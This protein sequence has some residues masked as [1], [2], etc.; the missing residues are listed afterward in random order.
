MTLLELLV[1]IGVD[2]KASPEIARLSGKISGT[3]KAVST[4]IKAGGAAVAAFAASSVNVGMQFDSAMSQVAATMGTTT[5]QISEL[6]DFAQEMGRT[7]A[8]SAT[9]AAEALNYMAL[10]GYDAQT[11]MNMLPTVL[12]LAAAGGVELAEASDMVTDVQSALGLTIE[13]TTAMVDQMAAASSRTN[14]SVAQLG[15]ALLTVGGTARNLSGGTIEAATALGLLADN[16]IKGAEGGT[17]LRNILLTLSSDKFS[18]T[19]GEMGVAV[20][21]ADGNMR[22][23]RDIIVDMNAAMEGMTVEEKTALLADTFNRVDLKSI[24]ALLGTNAE[25]W[26]EVTVAITDSAGAAEKMADTQLDNLGGDVTIFKSALEGLQIAISD[27]VSPALREFVQGATG[28]LSDLTAAIKEQGLVEFVTGLLN[29]FS[30]LLTVIGALSGAVIGFKAAMEA[31]AVMEAVTTAIKSFKAA[32][33]AATISQAVLNAV[34]NANPI[35]LIVSLIAMLVSALITLYLTNEDFRNALNSAWDVISSTVGGAIQAVISFVMSFVDSLVNAAS[36]AGE[37]ASAVIGAIA[38]IPGQIAG[39]V[40]QMFQA[41]AN[42]INGL[43]D[44]IQSAIGGV[45]NAVGGALSSIREMLPFS[46]AKKGPFSGH[47]WTLYSGRSLMQGLAEGIDQG[48]SM[49]EDAMA[50]A[51]G[52]VGGIGFQPAEVSFGAAGASGGIGGIGTTNIYIGDAIINA[53]D[54]I[55][56]IFMQGFT[57]LRQRGLM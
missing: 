52:L 36:Q 42:I 28:W 40:G 31:L 12:N 41:G 17:A 19:F 53:P 48:A 3:M 2:D 47:G 7:T 11:S 10:A 54:D 46:P 30:P 45:V 18:E 15:S 1:K 49:A 29:E 38:S 51:A 16:G 14:T 9:Q 55:K 13:Q 22:S 5:D 20:Y 50:R 32:N 39:F 25:R 27:G 24:N 43:K 35:V 57:E 33:E 6:R 34:M 37:F 44:G 23:L 56:R 4:A 8:F 21:D 26:D